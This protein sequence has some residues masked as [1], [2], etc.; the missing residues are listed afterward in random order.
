MALILHIIA[1]AVWLGGLLLMV[2]VRP[3]LG[4]ARS[5][6]ALGRYSS[7]ALVAFIVVAVSGTVRAVIG[8]RTWEALLSPYGVIL[9]VKIVALIA[10]GVLGAWYRRR[11]IGRL[12][13]DAASRR[14]WTPRRVRARPH[15]RRCGRRRRSRPHA[16]ARRRRRRPPCRRPPSG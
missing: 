7:I 3:V 10:L 6:A 5:A 16:S 14:F 8:L 15:G 9:S 1:A 2:L 13:E 12:R 11:L 4:R